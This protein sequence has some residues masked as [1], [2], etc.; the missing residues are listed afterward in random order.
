MLSLPYVKYITNGNLLYHSVNLNQGSVTN[1]RS[2]QC[3]RRE[4]VYEGGCI[5]LSVAGSSAGKE[6]TCNLGD[7]GSLPGLGQSPG[8]GII[9]PTPVFLG[10]PIVSI[11]KESACNVCDLNLIPGLGRSPGAEQ[12]NSLQCSCLENP[13]GQR[14]LVGYMQPMGSQRVGWT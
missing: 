4:G 14:I 2:G 1:F 12:G 7:F 11:G 5:C 3:G 10:F 8:E 6:S 9:L 13:H